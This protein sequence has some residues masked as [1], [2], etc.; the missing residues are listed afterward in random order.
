MRFL[1]VVVFEAWMCGS[2][3]TTPHRQ[4]S[5]PRLKWPLIGALASGL[6][7]DFL[8]LTIVVPILATL[9]HAD[10]SP[11]LTVTA[12]GVLFSAKAGWWR[13]L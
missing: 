3:L 8:L 4:Q 9:L 10:S 5:R 7:T 13:Q 6:F 1:I 12:I 2:C 11:R